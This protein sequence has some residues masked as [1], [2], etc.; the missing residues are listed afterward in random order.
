MRATK[1]WRRPSYPLAIIIVGLLCM[2]PG[3]AQTETQ[4]GGD[5]EAQ[6]AYKAKCQM[7]HAADG[8]GNTP[9]GKKL[10]AK[11]LKSQEVQSHSDAEL[12]T[13]IAKGKNKMPAFKG[14]LTDQQMLALVAEIRQWGHSAAK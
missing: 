1:L 8:S 11:D 7:C 6:Q 10:G 3:R 12:F 13:I 4:S 2:T 5:A 14:K 9:A